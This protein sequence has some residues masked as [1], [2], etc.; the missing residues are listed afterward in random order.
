VPKINEDGE[1]QVKE[2]KAGEEEEKLLFQEKSVSFKSYSEFLEAYH[3][4][5]EGLSFNKMKRLSKAYFINLRKRLSL[6]QFVY[7]SF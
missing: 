3:R 6:K 7:L 5:L 2:E 1:T 4:P